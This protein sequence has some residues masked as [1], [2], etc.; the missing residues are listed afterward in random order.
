MFPYRI[1]MTFACLL[2]LMAGAPLAVAHGQDAA[3][4][5]ARQAL[6]QGR[7][8]PLENIVRDALQRHPGKLLEVELDD[9]VYEVEILRADGVVIELD[10]DARSGALLKTE[11]D[12]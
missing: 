2:L 10:Y 12:D 6:K 9:G 11:L 8:V 7:Y 4:Q 5:T 1:L 3:Q